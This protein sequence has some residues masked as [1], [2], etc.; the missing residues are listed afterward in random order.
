MPEPATATARVSAANPATLRMLADVRGGLR[1]PQ[2]ELPPTY[3][4]DA[5][6]SRLF[7]EITRLPEYYPTRAERA[8]LVERATEIVELTRPRALAELGAGTADKS[9][10]LLRA[11]TK[12][13]VAEY[14]PIDVDGETLRAT[15]ESLREE[16]P[17][18][19]VS[20]IVA[21]MRDDVRAAGARHPLLYAF[22][23]S[24]IGNF[25]P[26][27]AAALLRRIRR[28]LRPT[29]RLLLG[30]DL[31]KDVAAL[32]AAYNDARGVTAEFN[33]NVLRVL[34]RELGA[35]FDLT[36]FAHRAFYDSE[37]RRIEMHLVACSAQCVH[38]PG[39]GMV[40]IAAGESIRTEISCK[41]DES[42]VRTL[43]AAS[44]FALARWMPDAA[45]QFALVLAEPA[46]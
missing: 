2:K 38:V 24:T 41:Y 26:P 3:F 22:L 23:G 29:D 17:T 19:V 13:R 45:R 14:L 46:A 10:I 6:G 40:A 9:R 43:L 44:G 21:D 16:F 8:L 32:E 27:D 25:A 20:P 15:A 18:L 5:Y 28:S 34:N 39:I 4:Y 37:Q 1:A 31:V 36:A 7:D 12:T 35:T 11:L 42:S 33:R 30:V